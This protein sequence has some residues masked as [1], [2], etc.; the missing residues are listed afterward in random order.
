MKVLSQKSDG[1]YDIYMDVS[2]NQL[3]M[4]YDK[5]AYA[6]II[7]DSL[8]T[9]EGE[10]QL[11]TEGGIPYLRTVFESLDK[12]PI[13]MFYVRKRVMSFDF[14]KDGVSLVTFE[15][16]DRPAMQLAEKEYGRIVEKVTGEPFDVVLRREILEPLD[17]ADTVFIPSPEQ[18]R[19]VAKDI[20]PYPWLTV[21]Y[22]A[23]NRRAVPDCGLFSTRTDLEAFARW[24]LDNP[25]LCALYF[26]SQTGSDCTRQFSFGFNVLSKDVVFF[27]S[28]TGCS[29]KIDR[30]ARTFEIKMGGRK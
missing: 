24:V 6:N 5:E 13:W 22:D 12:I 26:V 18:M 30:Q 7:E 19:R 28:A 8:R 21:P 10:L 1:T 17:M 20:L 16:A 11:D 9:L 25:S 23:P 15:G 4:S 3:A 29:L 2:T 27:E 14:V